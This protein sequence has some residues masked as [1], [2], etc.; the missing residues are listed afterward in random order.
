MSLTARIVSHAA[1]LPRLDAFERC[2]FIGPHPDDIEIGAGASAA[3]LRAMGKQVS[4]LICTDGRFGLEHA[5]AGTTP[6]ALAGIRQRESLE[7]AKLLGVEDVRFLPFSDG[8]LYDPRELFA[9]MAKAIGE[10]Q[11]DILFAP[12]PC[13]PSECHADHLNVG[14][15]ARRLALFAP[16]GEIMEAYGAERAPVKAVAFYMT[17]RPNRYMGTTG[18]LEHQRRA[19][20]CHKSQ[21]PEDSAAFRSVDL[22][23]KLRAA[24]FGLRSL[25]RSAEGFRVLGV[26]Q[27]HCLPEA[28]L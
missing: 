28:G 25:N 6:E 3:K 27:M 10:L 19:L 17:A 11:P 24:E 23:L 21:F 7:A 13:V 15:A 4:F 26:T 12:D 8:G 18:Y 22:Y 20:L 14:E 1:P 5:P 2:L 16:F 9:A